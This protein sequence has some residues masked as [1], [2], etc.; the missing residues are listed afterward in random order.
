M[1]RHWTAS[2][3]PNQSIITI[4]PMRI[5][6]PCRPHLQL[7]TLLQDVLIQFWG[8]KKKTSL[9]PLS[10]IVDGAYCWVVIR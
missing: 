5:F 6:S 8:E 10:V 2:F 9:A 7:D 4:T 1:K 3:I